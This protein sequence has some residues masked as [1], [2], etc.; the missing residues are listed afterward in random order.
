MTEKNANV[1]T[2]TANIPLNGVVYMIYDKLLKV[3]CQI[4]F[5]FCLFMFKNNLF[6]KLDLNK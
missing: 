3:N 5:S 6:E 2:Y 4:F 1:Y